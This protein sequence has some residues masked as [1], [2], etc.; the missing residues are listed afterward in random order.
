MYTFTGSDNNFK[1]LLGQQCF[2]S[3]QCKY[4]INDV[5]FASPTFAR[6]SGCASL[7]ARGAEPPNPPILIQ[8]PSIPPTPNI[9]YQ[10]SNM[11]LWKPLQT[12]S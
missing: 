10:L 3:I 8:A 1:F 12:E 4:I 11:A 9:F 6:I 2:F 5:V 7:G